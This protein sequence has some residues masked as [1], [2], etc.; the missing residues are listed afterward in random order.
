MTT[1]AADATRTFRV[2]WGP[3][4]STDTHGS[5]EFEATSE[6]EARAMTRKALEARFL[7]SH[8][9]RLAWTDEV[10]PTK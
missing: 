10:K 4:G 2:H 6:R 8:G 7:R 3:S 5:Y 9:W 1:Q